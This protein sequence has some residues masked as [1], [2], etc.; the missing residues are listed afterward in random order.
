MGWLA[1]EFEN[2]GLLRELNCHRT[3]AFAGGLGPL[4]GGA[5]AEAGQWRW[6][7]CESTM[8]PS[9]MLKLTLQRP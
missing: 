2:H 9:T 6:L 7:F 4:I 5:L 1:C 8:F 3:W